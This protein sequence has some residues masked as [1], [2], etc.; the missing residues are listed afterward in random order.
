MHTMPEPLPRLTHFLWG[1]ALAA[2]AACSTTPVA[3]LP[4]PETPLERP[5]ATLDPPAATPAAASANAAYVWSDA[6]ASVARKLRADL[7]SD[8][9]NIAQSADQ[10]VWLSFPADAVF[11]AGRSALLPRATPWLDRIAALV[12]ELPRAEL[13]ILGEADPTSRDARTANAQALDRAASARDWMVA[14]GVAARR[15]GVAGRQLATPSPR[16]ARRLDILIGER[17]PKLR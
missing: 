10:R 2:L 6:M 3:P 5:T 9:A 14:R 12:R 1:A 15:I 8:V 13:Q 17:A 7:P 16:E 11:A 4:A